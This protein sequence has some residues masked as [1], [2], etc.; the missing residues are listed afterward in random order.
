M[1]Y[2]LIFVVLLIVFLLISRGSTVKEVPVSYSFKGPLF[3]PAERT[4]LA[5]LN[6]ACGVNA[7][8]FGKVRVADVLKP[9]AGLNQ[10]Q[11]QS[12]F[13]Q[14][15]SKHFD[16][17]LCDPISLAVMAVVELDDSRHTQPKNVER[18]TFI[19]DV[20][21][22]ASLK[23]HRFSAEYAYDI[24]EMRNKIFPEVE[25]ANAA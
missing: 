21:A 15:S 17:I 16:Y 13:N 18:D 14:I 25:S 11:W 1:F 8:V 23:L 20:C 22:S 6:Q 2:I 9:Q 24:D 5:A 19:D 4:F 7:I 3:T 12:S 10:N